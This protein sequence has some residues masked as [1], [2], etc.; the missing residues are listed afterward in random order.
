MRSFPETRN[1]LYICVCELCVNIILLFMVPQFEI[2][3]NICINSARCIYEYDFK[4]TDR[5][6]NIK[7]RKAFKFT[8]IFV[9]RWSPGC[10][11]SMYYSSAVQHLV[12]HTQQL[13]CC[14]FPWDKRFEYKDN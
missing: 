5:W 12:I 11:K 3:Q 9:Q 8:S 13:R 2:I 7:V 6:K 10:C 1:V 4:E 14:D